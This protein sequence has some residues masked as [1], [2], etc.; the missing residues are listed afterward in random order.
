MNSQEYRELIVYKKAFSPARGIL[1]HSKIFPREELYSLT[2]Q[3]HGASRSV[4]ANLAEAY[5]KRRYEKHFIS[6]LNDSDGECGETMVLLDF[7]KEC[8]YISSDH[9]LELEGLYVAIGRKMGSKMNNPKFFL[10]RT[11]T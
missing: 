4:C 9:H 3:I 8:G 5:G 2:D 1:K 6:K 11:E 10:I 7:A